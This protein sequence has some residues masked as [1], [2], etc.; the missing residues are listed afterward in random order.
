MTT[1]S[2]AVRIHPDADAEK[3]VKKALGK[4]T[5]LERDTRNLQ[6]WQGHALRIDTSAPPTH[7]PIAI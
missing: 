7:T 3:S 1:N 6:T 4:E 2:T 5:L